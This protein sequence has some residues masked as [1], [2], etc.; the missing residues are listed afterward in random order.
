MITRAAIHT[1]TVNP[2]IDV[3]TTVPR[4]EPEVKLRCAQPQLDPGGG[5]INV[6]RVL[7]RLGAATVAFYAAG[8]HTGRLLGDLLDAEGI[9]RRPLEIGGNTR[10]DV[11]VGERSSGRQ[12]RFVMPGPALTEMEWTRCLR[13]PLAGDPRPQLLVA[14]GSL[15]AGMPVDFY[16]RLARAARAAGVA[17]VLDTSGAALEAATEPVHLLKLNRREAADLTGRPAS[18]PAQLGC[19]ALELLAGGRAETVVVSLGAE[20]ALLAT[21]GTVER[22]AAPPVAIASR[23][24][25]G[26]SM[27]AGIVFGRASGWPW[28]DAVQLGLAAGSA[29]VMAH[30]TNLAQPDD[31]RRLY[32][33]L[34]AGDGRPTRPAFQ[35]IGA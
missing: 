8:G 11:T 33:R 1:L 5:G 29:T 18:D 2:A 13:E 3:S 12:Y 21:A 28:R 19:G 34:R 14:S 20:G 7:H 16:A 17:L 15:A 10:E 30:G 24:G 6:A 35:E 4:L 31:V 26:D 9:D 23:I 22:L 27:V 25:A 32:T